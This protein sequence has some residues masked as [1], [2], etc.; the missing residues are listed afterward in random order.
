MAKSKAKKVTDKELDSIKDLQQ[1]IN[2]VVMNLGN[3]VV[4]QD[5]LTQSHQELQ[6]E[7]KK[8]TAKL[9][10]KYGN[11]NISLEDGSISELKEE[12]A[13]ELAKV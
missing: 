4:V 10:K 12:E 1:R 6:K 9:E 8:A 7:W 11:V 5:Q 2:T 13:P 3:A